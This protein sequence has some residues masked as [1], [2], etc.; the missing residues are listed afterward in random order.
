MKIRKSGVA[1]A[2]ATLA[3][4]ALIGVST[5]A[6]ADTPSLLVWL[7]S[8]K[9]ATY[10]TTINDWAKDNGVTVTIVGKDFG[11]VRDTLKTAVPAGTGPDLL[12]GA[13]HDWTGNLVSAG[14]VRPINLPAAVAAGLTTSSL[15]AFNVNGKQ[16]GVPAYTE[17]LGF[18]RNVK[19]AKTK[20]TSLSQIKNGELRVPYG[21]TGGDGYHFYP[22]QTA[23]G[24][25]VFE[26][27][28]KGWTS[29]IA[30][31]GSEGAAFANFLAKGTKFFGTGGYSHV[32]DFI[33]GKAKYLITGPWA[34]KDV[35]QGAAGCTTGLKYGTGFVVESFPKGP[36]GIQGVPF[37][38]AK[39]SFL[40]NSPTT[41]VVNAT[42]LL[43][44]LAGKEAGVAF[45]NAEYA[46]PANK[47]ALAVAS[48]SVELK[49]FAA[50]AKNA[51]VLP[52]PNITAMDSVWDKWGKTEAKIIS[53]KSTS[54]SGDWKA[55]TDA[56]IEMLK[57]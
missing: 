11:S 20:V 21:V 33:N 14:V 35:E 56:I 17:N 13:A 24:A 51:D 38:G 19:V 22:L 42:R 52:M 4:S 10:T 54:P 6:I 53:G 31:D 37:L 8:D 12:V 9:K 44:Y 23:F 39:G 32:C 40:T 47:A 50:I 30:M 55:M 2:V 25:K 43:T 16:Y 36:S 49:A 3:V 46:T 5:P 41:D 26:H 7:P 45:F 57:K 15:A 1:A 48:N 27:T 34:L 29:T 18:F 28:S